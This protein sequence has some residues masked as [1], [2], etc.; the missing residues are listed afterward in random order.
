MEKAEFRRKRF[1]D[2]PP[3]VYPY[4]LGWK[5]NI[6]L[7]FNKGFN[8]VGNG[9][10][11]PVVSGCDQYTLTVIIIMQFECTTSLLYNK[12]FV[13]IQFDYLRTMCSRL[14]KLS[15]KKKSVKE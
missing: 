10:D 5:K 13:F 6:R 12:L 11:W 7:V 4:D 3:F 9:I 1:V 14:S 15:R 8:P 2:E